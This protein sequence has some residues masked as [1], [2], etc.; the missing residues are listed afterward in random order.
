NHDCR[1]D[2]LL[3]DRRQWENSVRRGG[4]LEFE[5][6]EAIARRLDELAVAD[7]GQRQA[8]DAPVLHL[9][10]D[11]IIDLVGADAAAASQQRNE[12]EKEYAD[13]IH[14][15]LSWGSNGVK[16][17]AQHLPIFFQALIDLA[18]L[19]AFEAIQTKALDGE[20]RYY[21]AIS[22]R[23]AQLCRPIRLGA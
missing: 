12:S 23:F 20:A 18:A 8:G 19:G 10:L 17:E 3:A 15:V 2:E 13:E 11:E 21:G 9:D 4:R 16:L 14:G 22:H 7:N 1:G 6:G 5:V